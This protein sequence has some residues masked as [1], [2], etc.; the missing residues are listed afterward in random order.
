MG[1]PVRGQVALKSG[2]IRIF[3]PEELSDSSAF[4][5]TLI[6]MLLAATDT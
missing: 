3:S 4:G 2:L 6:V 1:G 5:G